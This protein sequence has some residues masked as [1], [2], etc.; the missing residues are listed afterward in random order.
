VSR[1]HT[2]EEI[3]K[4]AGRH[5]FEVSEEEIDGEAFKVELATRRSNDPNASKR[6]FV[7]DDQLFHTDGKTY[8]LTNQWSK[9]SMQALLK[10]FSDQFGD[11][12]F[13]IR[14]TH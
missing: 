3:E 4:V 6:F 13:S 2:P 1:G 5:L 14:A 11:Y 7:R 12:G 10:A 8:A 9:T